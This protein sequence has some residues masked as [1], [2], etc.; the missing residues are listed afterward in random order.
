MGEIG[1]V[2]NLQVKIDN[3]GRFFL[4]R[5][6]HFY[7]NKC[8]CDLTLLFSSLDSIKSVK[9]HYI[10]LSK[11]KMVIKKE[12][13]F[14]R[15]I[16]LFYMLVQIILKLWILEQMMSMGTSLSYQ[17]KCIQMW[18]YQLLGMVASIYKN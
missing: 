11:I 13:F 2:P 17:R 3:W 6:H 7:R 5:L 9:V 1:E 16:E 8:H 10:N 12:I 14:F 18:L 4:Q 15:F